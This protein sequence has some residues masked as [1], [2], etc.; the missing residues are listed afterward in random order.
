MKI[1]IISVMITIETFVTLVTDRLRSLYCVC[2]NL[3]PIILKS[4]V[5]AAA[6]RTCSQP[7][8]HPYYCWIGKNSSIVL[9]RPISASFII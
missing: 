8:E 6:G 3:D 4:V 5:R 7:V 1:V 2:S 9:V